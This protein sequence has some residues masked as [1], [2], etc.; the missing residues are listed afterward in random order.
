MKVAQ[1]D[2]KETIDNLERTI[3]N[4]HSWQDIK[5]H[6]N[7][8][9]SCLEINKS[10]IGLQED[11]RKYNSRESL[12]DVE[13]T[14]YSKIQ[15]MVREFTPY[16]NLWV[17]ADQ[18][19]TNSKNWLN[20]EWETLDAVAAEK[21]VEESVRVLAGVNRFFKE[22]DIG[23]VLKI[24]QSVKEQIDE[25]KPKVP[26]MVSLRKKGLVERHWNQIS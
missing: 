6:E 2:F 1:E 5:N 4:F 15:M 21:F 9:K 17:T 19:F 7:A 22:R 11:A 3:Q 12:F 8:A 18:W 13:T 14:D 10:L 26:L 20:G 24:A 16:S 23:P 25:F